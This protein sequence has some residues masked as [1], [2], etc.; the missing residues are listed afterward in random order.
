M[1]EKVK[2]HQST[3]FAKEFAARH[4]GLKFHGEML[5]IKHL[6]DVYKVMK[7]FNVEDETILMACYLKNFLEE[8]NVPLGEIAFTFGKEVADIVNRL[9]H[10]EGS[11]KVETLTKTYAKIKGHEAA[12]IVKLCERISDVEVALSEK[13]HNQIRIYQQDYRLMK[14]LMF[15]DGIAAKMWDKLDQLLRSK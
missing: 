15:V 8:T 14:E 4:L 10:N 11:N 2:N 6:N 1:R 5:F 13:K 12:T 9:T 3:I 7:R